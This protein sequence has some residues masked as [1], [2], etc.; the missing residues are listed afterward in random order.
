M[1]YFFIV[2]HINFMCLL[3]VP[4]FSFFQTFEKS[5]PKIP[6]MPMIIHVLSTFELNDTAFIC[7]ITGSFL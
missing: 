5:H 7:N 1:L 3:H 6:G 2:L 4:N